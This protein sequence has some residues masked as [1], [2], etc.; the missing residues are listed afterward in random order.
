[1]DAPEHMPQVQQS[2]TELF[3]LKVHKDKTDFVNHLALEIDRLILHDFNRLVSLLYRIDID[4]EELKQMLQQ[5]AHT[6]AGYIIAQL[7]IKRQ[8][9]K[10]E[11]R[12]KFRTED[13]I[14]EED[15]W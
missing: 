15:K 8:L 12:K 14:A 13:D 5:Y 10:A 11:S 4:E 1:M 7:I 9:A 6:D 3:E 2:L